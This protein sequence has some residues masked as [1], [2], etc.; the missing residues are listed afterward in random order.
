MTYRII[1][2]KN[3]VGNLIPL[4]E[5]LKGTY[6][7][8]TFYGTNSFYNVTASNNQVYV[9]DNAANFTVSLTAGAYSS[10]TLRVEIQTQ[11]NTIGNGNVYTVAYD[12]D[13]GKY[14]ITADT[15]NYYFTF[16]T[17]TTNSAHRLLGLD[18]SDGSAALTQVSENVIELSIHP[19]M[20]MNIK[21]DHN[22]QIRGQNHFS[23]S[24]LLYDTT[25]SFGDP[26]RMNLAGN[27]LY[28][29]FVKFNGNKQLEISF[30]NDDYNEVSFQGTIWTLVL[31]KISEPKRFL[32]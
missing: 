30:Y 2:S 23:A 15:N 20:Y 5:E 18:A 8:V 17:N 1:N 25:S 28:P 6:R 3:I 21:Q 10:Q 13:S 4:D 14:T 29:Q 31:Q 16:A 27:H 26:F 9:N 12:T 7:L 24:L 22:K 32:F 19:V 11:L